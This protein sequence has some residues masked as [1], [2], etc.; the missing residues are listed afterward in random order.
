MATIL[1]PRRR[2]TGCRPGFTIV[3]LAIAIGI[4]AIMAAM[5]LPVIDFNRYRM[6]ANAR[7]VQNVLLGAQQRA[8]QRNVP[9]LVI[10]DNWRAQFQLADD[11]NGDGVMSPTEIVTYISVAEGMNFETPPT[12]ID[13]QAT[14][15]YGT[16]PGVTMFVG[17][18]MLTFFPNGTSSGDAVVY[19]GSRQGRLQDFRAIKMTA[20]TARMYFYRMRADGTWALSE[21]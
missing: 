2:S 19:L 9:V 3:E 14:A 8:V 21:M 16:G 18:P 1:L 4:A 20:A 15:T 13:G 10:L 6:D 11:L 12:T 5:A 17:Y 7:L